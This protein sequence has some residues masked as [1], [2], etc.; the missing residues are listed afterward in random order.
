MI[1]DTTFV[2]DLLHERWRGRPA[3]ASALLAKRRAQSF[4]LTIINAGEISV[5]FEDS[6][7]AWDW[8]QD[9]PM[10]R[11]HPGIMDCA[12]DLDRTMIGLGQRLGENDTWIA[13]FALYFREA[14]VSRDA[15]FDRVSG[16][17]RISY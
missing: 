3:A 8:L 11:L 13:G 9:W 4:R 15:A 5:L 6:V 2:S 7:A 12:A 17:R 14:L 1:V 10:Y 16:I